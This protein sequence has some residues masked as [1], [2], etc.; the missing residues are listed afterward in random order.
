[1]A[2]LDI[3]EEN[4]FPCYTIE[5]FWYTEKVSNFRYHTGF[6][7]WCFWTCSDVLQFSIVMEKARY[8]R[9]LCPRKSDVMHCRKEFSLAL[10]KLFG[11]ECFILL[12]SLASHGLWGMHLRHTKAFS[13]G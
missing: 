3:K 9:V 7:S 5:Q 1:M 10:L 6:V 13:Q 2:M 4:H 12:H 11:H 8:V